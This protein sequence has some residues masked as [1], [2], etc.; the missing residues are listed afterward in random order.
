M[1]LRREDLHNRNHSFS[2]MTAFGI[3]PVSL[4]G[5][6][7]P[8]RVWGTLVTTNYFDV[9]AV[10]PVLGRGFLPSE[11]SAANGAPVAVISYRLWE[12]H[13]GWVVGSTVHIDT[14]PFTIVGVA[15]PVFQGSYTGLRTLR[16]A[17]GFSGVT[18]FGARA[19]VLTLRRA[20]AR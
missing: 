1:L 4:T 10:R 12:D 3:W 9:L 6:G 7:K 14:H 18:A 19:R 8:E 13:F 5:Q 2:D 20:W 17:P 15:P 11:E 16:V